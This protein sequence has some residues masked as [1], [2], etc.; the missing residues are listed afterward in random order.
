MKAILFL[1]CLLAPLWAKAQPKTNFAPANLELAWQLVSNQYNG[2][3]QF[4]ATLRLTNQ[5]KQPLPA[6]GWAIYYN[7]NRDLA[8]R[9]LGHGL[10]AERLVGDLFRLRPTAS[11]KGLGPK[12]SVVLEI[13]SLAWAL[14]VSDAPAGPYWV[15]D[16]AP[17]KPLPL[18]PVRVLPPADPAKLAWAPNQPSPQVTPAS[19]FAQNQAIAD[20][21]AAQ[22]PKIFPTPVSYVEKAGTFMLNASTAISFDPL[23]AQEADY[24][25]EE[26]KVFLGTKPQVGA[27]APA[28]V[29]LGLDASLAAEEYRLEI[30]TAG[31]RLMAASPRGAFYAVQSLKCLLPLEAWQAPQ[32]ALAV[33]GALVRDA[34][35]FGYR[36][37]HLDVA[38]NFQSKAQLFRLLNWMAMYKLNKLHFHFSDDEAWR[39]EIPALPE[40]T[41]V[42]VQRGH[43]LDSKA[44]LPATYGSGGDLNNPHS[45]FYSRSDYVELVRYAKARHIEIIPEIETPGHARAA[46]K[47]M[48]Y[49][50]ARLLAEQKP[51]AAREY[52]LADPDDQ[53][54]YLSVQLFP[55]NVMCVA[56]PSVYRFI[57]TTVDALVAMHQEAGAPL[58][59]IHFGGDELPVGAWE[60]SPLC[61]ALLKQLPPDEYRQT[62]DLWLYYWR[63]I[64]AIAQ[65]RNLYVSGWEEIGLRETQLDGKRHLQVNPT[66]ANDR[67]QV[68]VWNTVIGWGTEDLPYRLAN[69][70]YPVVMCPVGNTYFDLAYQPDFA[71]PGYYW[72]GFVDVDKPF[73]LIPLDFLKNTTTDRFG[74]A[75]APNALVGKERLTDFG[76][77]NIVG[78]QG[79]LWSENA[80]QPGA[81]EYMALPKMLGLAERAWAPDPEWATTPDASRGQA[82]YQRAWS[83]FANVVG[84]RELFKL[85]FYQGGANFRVPTVGAKVVDG[86]VVANLQLPG[87]T[88]RYTTD[89]SEPSAKSPA[90]TG[91][92]AAKGL[93]RLRAFDA[94]A[95]GGRTVQVENR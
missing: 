71:E 90:Y 51:E 9:D 57:E 88:I 45:G 61:Q 26:L 67:F 30:T 55:D 84:K 47:A 20:L 76:K 48:N 54:T 92:I 27:P 62:S 19:V 63:K 78:I 17:A 38:R 53:S 60:K 69:G 34:P 64:K 42:G 37:L 50:Q 16:A 36:G 46:I 41:T 2:A 21:P 72:G 65:A 43:T 74:Q 10:E 44:H 79:Q 82:L 52:L 24:L 80:R 4:L 8:R 28:S 1:C 35:R 86:A 59:T 32:P 3:N 29:H 5:G 89:G 40:L 56:L 15:W 68:Y 66:F 22:L 33:P 18:A 93:I 12:Q 70:G 87:L 7:A 83:E 73:A 49:R 85:S 81:L 23:F 75:L 58:A 91:P 6:T 13:V 95:R 11:F 14:N 77:R 31:V 25:A 94:R 39:I